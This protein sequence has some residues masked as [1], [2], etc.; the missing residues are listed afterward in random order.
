MQICI[1]VYLYS[2]I[3]RSDLSSLVMISLQS[4]KYMLTHFIRYWLQ[5][6]CLSQEQFPT[7]LRATLNK[8]RPPL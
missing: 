4:S 6:S 1:A 5:I 7:Q 8:V 2:I 3:I